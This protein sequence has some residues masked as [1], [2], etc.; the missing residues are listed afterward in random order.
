MILTWVLNVGVGAGIVLRVV[1]LS[2]AVLMPV[3]DERLGVEGVLVHGEMSMTD[4]D[5]N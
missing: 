2:V 3:S 1:F 5:K 4:S